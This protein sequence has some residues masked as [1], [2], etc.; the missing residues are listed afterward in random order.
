MKNISKYFQK[1]HFY[2][3]CD[4][5]KQF[6][7]QCILHIKIVMST[8]LHIIILHDLLGTVFVYCILRC[9]G[10]KK[11]KNPRTLYMII[12]KCLYY[13]SLPGDC[14]R[15]ALFKRYALYHSR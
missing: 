1:T 15:R 7:V 14:R 8:N 12:Y 13:A 4:V 11:V 5:Y 2:Y 10:R 9:I 3:H 6:Y